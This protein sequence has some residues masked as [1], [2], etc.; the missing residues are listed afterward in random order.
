MILLK[1]KSSKR[2][3]SAMMSA[4]SKWQQE[5]LNV[6][7][8]AD[9]E[10]VVSRPSSS[11]PG[12]ATD[13]TAEPINC[14]IHFVKSRLLDLRSNQDKAESDL[15]SASVISISAAPFYN[16]LGVLAF[17]KR[18]FA[19]SSLYFLKASQENQKLRQSTW[20]Q[21][22]ADSRKSLPESVPDISTDVTYNM[23]LQM[24]LLGQFESAMRCFEEVQDRIAAGGSASC[25]PALLQLRLA[26]AQLAVYCAKVSE[27]AES[28]L[29]HAA[30]P[31]ESDAS[32]SSESSTT[33]KSTTK[34]VTKTASE[35]LRE[36]GWLK[37]PRISGI[38]KD[39]LLESA[40]QCATTAFLL[41]ERFGKS[42]VPAPTSF[43][44]RGAVGIGAIAAAAAAS[45]SAQFSL[46]DRA[47]LTHR[48]YLLR[49]YVQVMLAWMSLESDN[50]TKALEWA[51]G[52][53]QAHSELESALHS[54]GA[55]TALN[56]GTTSFTTSEK[57]E[58][59]HYY[60]LAH[61]YHAEA[62]LRL[63]N[64]AGALTVLEATPAHLAKY[65][66]V[67]ATQSPY[68][69]ILDASVASSNARPAMTNAS[70]SVSS[71]T[72]P[73]AGT[74]AISIVPPKV[75]LLCNMAAVWIVKKDL[76]QAQKLVS[77]ALTQ[78]PH[79]LPAISLQ[80]YLELAAGNTEVAVRLMCDYRV[81]DLVCVR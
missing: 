50:L 1:I 74:A 42:G 2:E 19:V 3:I 36:G 79:L 29:T 57:A 52:A 30:Q 4:Y 10:T 49:V 51:T 78:V 61:L 69:P 28:G 44:S 25:S 71:A 18:K 56:D 17:H 76:A 16:S 12:S 32:T 47:Q 7:S 20:P 26:E 24:L 55:S 66:L 31:S 14:A 81:H 58:F 5:K 63:G 33:A 22:L 38:K 37:L 40:L 54:T 43:G 65:P 59:D 53:R 64:V 70:S 6:G 72:L 46:L 75:A 21:V 39:P 77:Q 11:S 15:K 68:S 8:T 60:F 9:G 34:S 23:G 67:P 41:F 27:F 13:F 45:H 48:D 80:I 62:E 35:V 73:A